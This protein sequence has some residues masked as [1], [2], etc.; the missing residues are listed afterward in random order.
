[1]DNDPFLP[2]QP[3]PAT[4]D[5]ATGPG[6]AE[7]ATPAPRRHGWRGV[8]AG[9]AAGALMATAVAVPVAWRVAGHQDAS[10][11]STAVAT[12]PVA[13]TTDGTTDGGTATLPDTGT[14][15]DQ[16]TLPGQAPGSGTGGGTTYGGPA[17]S[18]SATR[19]DATDAQSAGVVLID[20]TLTDGTG[21][22]TGLVIGSD[23]LVLTNYH[24][25]EDSTDV[26]VTIATTGKTYDAEVVG[27]DEAADVALLRLD[28]ASGLTTVALDDDGGAA[29]DDAV[30]AIGNAEGQGYLSASS[31]DVVAVDQDITTSSSDGSAD[32]SLTGLLE[33]DAAVVPGYSGGALLDAEGEV[34]GITT[35]A[36]SGQVAESYAVPIATAL[37]VVDQIE[38][39]TET[40]A[41]EIGPSAY[42][43]IGVASQGT[44][45]VTVAEVESGQAAA[46]AGIVAGDTVTGLGGTRITSYD[47]LRSVLA[48]HEPGDSVRI[49]WTDADGAAHHATVTLGSSPVN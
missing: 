8:L 37:A 6:P 46:G 39:G 22:G 25:V 35:A 34:V 33:M 31:G 23:G 41:V 38:S 5:H 44:G 21:A 13:G 48:A 10:T 15:P 17:Q 43:G 7:A 32:E 1:M 24:V 40:S 4:P 45:G 28:D 9:A 11:G 3:P 27:H 47:D 26:Q 18:S 29:V 30:T 42:L 2:Q 20:T 14:L 36:S 16:G 49:A 12:S 19:T